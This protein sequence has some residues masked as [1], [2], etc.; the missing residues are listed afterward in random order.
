MS[1]KAPPCGRSTPTRPSIPPVVWLAVALWVGSRLAEGWAWRVWE[2]AGFP[3]PGVCVAVAAWFGAATL[4]VRRRRRIGA[5]DA[6]GTLSVL[7]LVGLLLGCGVSAMQAAS[8][9]V[10]ARRLV[11]AGARD[12][13]GVVTADPRDGAYGASIRVRASGG[14]YDA[15]VLSVRLPSGMSAPEYGRLVRFSAI[16]KLRDCDERGRAAARAGEN[17][18]A[19]A[20]VLEDVGW[21][22]GPV[23]A[24]CAWRAGAVGRLSVVRGD[25]GALLRG[26]VLGDRRA[27]TGS[28]V[29]EDFRVLGLSHVVAVSG[30]H[31]AVV[32]GVCLRSHGA[33]VFRSAG[34]S[35][36]S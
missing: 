2:G 33:H 36:A 30:S 21:P 22:R 34:C 9:Q 13:T 31:L 17:A 12:W 10:M 7:C 20:W 23:G 3:W 11:D 8:W 4:S 19:N 1:T 14:P 27:L 6:L 5:W 32:C 18:V 28:A 29:D 35:W 24:L 26:V 15:A 16:P 25:A